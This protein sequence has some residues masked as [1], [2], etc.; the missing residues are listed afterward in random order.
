MI[1]KYLSINIINQRSRLII[2]LIGIKDMTSCVKNGN[3]IVYGIERGKR[4]YPGSIGPT[5]S[6][7]Q[8]P[9]GYNNYNDH[10]ED[11]YVNNIYKF[12]EDNISL[13]NKTEMNDDLNTSGDILLQNRLLSESNINSRTFNS[14]LNNYFGGPTGYINFFNGS[15]ND[16]DRRWALTLSNPYSNL[17]FTKY[18]DSGNLLGYDFISYRDGL[19]GIRFGNSIVLPS[20]GNPRSLLD[21]YEIILTKANTYWADRPS[22]LK[23]IILVRIGSMV[24]VSVP[25]LYFQGPYA[26]Y[27]ISE[28]F[29]ESNKY[30]PITNQ[31]IRPVYGYVYSNSSPILLKASYGSFSD[32]GGII[33]SMPNDQIIYGDFL[34]IPAVTYTFIGHP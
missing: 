33:I 27:V 24:M 17:Q 13:H 6:Q 1:V 21:Y 30:W 22:G 8:G 5:G 10:F 7:V 2:L 34:L 29:V 25:E 20:E 26:G 12:H 11:I 23:D 28:N 19:T 14:H 4:G 3:I 15:T 32:P 16:N 31:S 9:T 18:N